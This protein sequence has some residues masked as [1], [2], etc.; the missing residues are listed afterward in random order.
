[1]KEKVKLEG[2]IFAICVSSK[3]NTLVVTYAVIASIPMMHT[4]LYP[5]KGRGRNV[6][7][8]SL[9]DFIFLSHMSK[10]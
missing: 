7:I 1:M 10:P 5:F 6:R 9:S 8:I 3:D 2:Q 4:S